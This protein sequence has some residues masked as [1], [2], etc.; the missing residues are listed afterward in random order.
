MQIT[1]IF[2]ALLFISLN[3]TAQNII[4]RDPTGAVVATHT[5]TAPMIYFHSKG[6]L[7]AVKTDQTLIHIFPDVRNFNFAVC[8]LGTD[9]T[10]P[11]PANRPAYLELD[12]R[13]YPVAQFAT[14]SPGI[15]D[16]GFATAQ[17]CRLPT[18]PLPTS[19]EQPVVLVDGV[20]IKL[21]TAS[22][23]Q[24]YITYK[25]TAYALRITTIHEN[26]LC[27]GAVPAPAEFVTEQI[28]KAGFEG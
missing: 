11:I 17:N 25:A 19:P 5:V 21:K 9:P 4:V 26:V 10:T 15:Y 20:P 14:V 13:W 24:I 27:D 3:A 18:G 12:G 1:T 8:E 7:Q 23:Q 2:M 16:T 22:G 6:Y 28:F